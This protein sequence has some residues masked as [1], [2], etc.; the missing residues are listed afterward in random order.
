MS[1]FNSTG[2]T[3]QFRQ[4]ASHHRN[5]DPG[6]HQ[7]HPHRNYDLYFHACPG[8]VCHNCNP[9]CPGTN[10]DRANFF[11]D[12]AFVPEFNSAITTIKFHQYAAHNRNLE[13]GD[14][15]HHPHRDY[16][17]HF[18]THDRGVCH[19]HHYEYS[20]RYPDCANLQPD[21]SVVSEFNATG[22]TNQFN[23]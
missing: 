18:Y 1:E 21:R 7:H 11:P 20:G 13:S 16:D 8:A 4:F 12:R 19:Y 5:L 14:N 23:Q 6:N 2:I 9:V 15:Q 10:P 22:F 17:L 3:H